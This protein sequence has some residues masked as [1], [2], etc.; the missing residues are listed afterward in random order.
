MASRRSPQV[1]WRLM[2]CKCWE[3]FRQGRIRQQNELGEAQNRSLGAACWPAGEQ[4]GLV[5]DPRGVCLQ[6]RPLDCPSRA[7][8][9]PAQTFPSQL[10]VPGGVAAPESPQ[11]G[12]AD[13]S[14]RRRGVCTS[15]LSQSCPFAPGHCRME[16]CY[17]PGWAPG[18]LSAHLLATQDLLNCC[19][20]G[21]CLNLGG[22]GCPHSRARL[23]CW[24]VEEAGP[25]GWHL[26][27]GHR[28]HGVRG[29]RW[30]LAGCP[31]GELLLRSWQWLRKLCVHWEWR[32]QPKGLPPPGGSGGR[33][34]ESWK[35]SRGPSLVKGSL[36]SVQHA[37]L[38]GG[39]SERGAT[40]PPPQRAHLA[41]GLGVSLSEIPC[42]V[43]CD[44]C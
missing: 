21:V 37:A 36:A 44:A 19:L 29:L 1:A 4:P 25:V 5:C 33:G 40:S 38:L 43:L 42:L 41:S 27:P 16:C 3:S 11:T 35:G 22:G 24:A 9:H 32:P 7:S 17:F 13:S 28:P 31:C 23:Q 2:Y 20:G 34:Q 39:G 12:A 8:H 15:P 30:R 14:G 26:L 10:Q 6:G 18:S